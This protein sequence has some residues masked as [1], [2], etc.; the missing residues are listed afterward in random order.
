MKNTITTNGQE[1]KSIHTN[2]AEV[3]ASR[4]SYFPL[5]DIEFFEWIRTNKYGHLWYCQDISQSP[6]L[7][8]A[9]KKAIKKVGIMIHKAHC[10]TLSQMSSNKDVISLLDLL[11]HAERAMCWCHSTFTVLLF[12]YTEEGPATIVTFLLTASNHILLN[13]QD[14]ILQIVQL[15]Q[16]RISHLFSILITNNFI[17]EEVI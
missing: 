15:I 6:I 11:L 16:Y 3:H 7:Q 5:D 9:I 4:V 8:C 12:F 13:M 2:I 10:L 14:Q 1:R 17:G